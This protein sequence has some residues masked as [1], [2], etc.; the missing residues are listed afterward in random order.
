MQ[1]LVVGKWINCRKVDGDLIK[2]YF[3]SFTKSPQNVCF[4][5]IF[6]QCYHKSM[7]VNPKCWPTQKLRTFTQPTLVPFFLSVCLGAVM[8][9]VGLSQCCSPAQFGSF[10]TSTDSPSSKQSCKVITCIIVIRF[11]ICRL[12]SHKPQQN[13][14]S[15]RP[16]QPASPAISALLT[17]DN[18]HAKSDSIIREL[19]GGRFLLCPG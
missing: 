14:N 6:P 16:A 12:T 1:H 18:L 4:A 17:P 15:S 11:F 9:S 7:C 5:L 19:A 2:F 10:E 13:C 3:H 8:L